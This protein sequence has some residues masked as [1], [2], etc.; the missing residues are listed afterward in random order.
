[1]QGLGPIGRRAVY[2]QAARPTPP[3]APP[4]A[5]TVPPQAKFRFRFCGFSELA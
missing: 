1:M 5:A 3:V 2:G 4:A